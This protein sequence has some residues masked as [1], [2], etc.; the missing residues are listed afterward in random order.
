MDQ[1][2]GTHH[3]AAVGVPDHLQPQAHAE[4]RQARPELA[5]DVEGQAGVARMTRARRD[6]H[7]VDAERPHVGGRAR[8]VA[9]DDRPGPELAQVLDEVVDERVVV[10]DDEDGQPAAGPFQP[11]R[12][13]HWLPAVPRPPSGTAGSASASASMRA[14]SSSTRARRSTLPI[15]VLGSSSRNSTALGTL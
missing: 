5:D 2:R 13:P 11:G 14:R 10:V 7:P 6:Q 9:P 4:D 3:L 15:N 8:V 12:S 1:L